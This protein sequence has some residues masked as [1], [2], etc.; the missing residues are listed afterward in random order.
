MRQPTVMIAG[1]GIGG[2]A[3]ALTLDQIG[4]RCVVFESVKALRPLGV[5]INIQPNAVRE[6]YDLGIGADD[7]DRI[8]VPTREWTLVGRNGNEI[9]SEPRGLDAGYDWPQYSVHRGQLQMLL[10]EKVLE[11]LAP[12]TVRLGHRVTGYE[13]NADGTV[14]AFI[15]TADG[16]TTQETGTLLVGSD[17]MHSTVRAQMHPDQPPVHWGG[18]IMWRG[19]STAKPIRSD[20]SFLGLG[21]DRQRMV[22]Y[23]I[24]P[25]DPDSGLATINWIAEVTVDNSDGWQDSDWSK[26]V[27]LKHFI[28]HFDDWTFDWLDVPAL[29]RAAG[30]DIW[31]YP[32]VD[33]DPVA[34]W[35]DGR[36]ALLGD[37]AHV[38]YPTG[39]NGAGQ[40]IVD[41]RVLGACLI[42]H[43]VTPQALEAY[44]EKLCEP[45]S[46]LVLR[47]RGAGPFGLLK[48]VDERCG[49]EFDHIDDIIPPEERAAF[50]SGYKTAAGFAVDE[51][52]R[53][54]PTI[55]PG[56]R[57]AGAA[58]A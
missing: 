22:I 17:G 7:L 33:R 29:L 27:D 6:L 35:V 34:T 45:V 56:A 23:P 30:Q 20:A 55:A 38:M 53:A 49:G 19:T 8:G 1:G 31:E 13:N 44:N 9:Y 2:L 48:I 52:N 43:G 25:A 14:T 50:V 39:S 4:V 5:G 21:T 26:R 42:E 40:A 36:V 15:E 16:V 57:V 32:M 54:P 12:E 24:S 58:T 11:R 46:Q 10:Y 37:A 47:N 28:H 41:G 3:L 18:A 51:L